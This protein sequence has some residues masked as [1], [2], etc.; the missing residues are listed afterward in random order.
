[1]RKALV[2]P[3]IHFKGTG[4]A[5]KDRAASATSGRTSTQASSAG[6]ATAKNA[7]AAGTTGGDTGS[8]GSG[9]GPAGD[10]AG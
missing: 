6:P 5:K 10:A 1:M 4:W 9:S 3:A 7:P 8:G 2:A